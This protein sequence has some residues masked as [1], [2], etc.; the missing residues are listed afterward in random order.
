MEKQL[1]LVSHGSFA[2]EL[3]RS[4]DMIM[5]P[6]EGIHAIGLLESEGPEDFQRVK[7]RRTSKSKLKPCWQ[8][9]KKMKL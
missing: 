4:T 1:I 2:A 5:G 7:D 6:Q 8:T 9:I 3:K